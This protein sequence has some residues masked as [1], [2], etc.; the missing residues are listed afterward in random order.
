MCGPN[1]IWYWHRGVGCPV[2]ENMDKMPRR[3]RFLIT[4]AKD[5]YFKSYA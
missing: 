1:G 5:T 4:F 2:H 3:R